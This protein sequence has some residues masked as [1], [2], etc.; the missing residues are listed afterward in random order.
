M[1]PYMSVLIMLCASFPEAALMSYFAIQ[2]MGGKPKIIEVILIG[3]IQAVIAYIVRTSPIPFGAHTIIQILTTIVLIAIIARV[4]LISAIIGFVC[5]FIVYII[6]SIL[7]EYLITLTLGLTMSSIINHPYFRFV[8]FVPIALVF[9]MIILLFKKY[10]INFFKIAKWQE[11]GNKLT[12]I[13]DNNGKYVKSQ[14]VTA[15]IFVFLPLFIL[16]LVNSAY[17]KVEVTDTG[18]YNSKLFIIMF[19]SLIV[20]MALVSIWSLNK[21]NRAVQKEYEATKAAE[22]I[23]QLKELILSIRKQRHDFNHHM[24]AVFGLIG[25]GNYLGA[26]SYIENTYHYAFNTG[27]LIKTDNPGISALLYTKIGIADTRN[28]Y[29][30]INIECSL[31]DFPLNSN[32]TSSL[33]GNLVDNAFDAVEKNSPENRKISLDITAERG[34]YQIEVTNSGQLSDQEIKDILKAG[35]TTK[36]GHSGLG[37]V[38]TKEIV[39]K[40]N[41]SM[42]VVSE[43]GEIVFSINIPFKR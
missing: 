5:V 38:I 17:V 2:F 19:N 27:E 34:M 7:I 20:V 14:Y 1:D 36:D 23:E 25:S 40:Y 15:L 30:E 35:Y 43:D 4:Q 28:I 13:D 32:E 41:G 12:I 42:H 11:I 31:E 39:E 9:L 22:T 3:L 37:L 6:D 26:R 8:L 24:Q 21:I 18:E 16:Y 29:F 10:E 33:I